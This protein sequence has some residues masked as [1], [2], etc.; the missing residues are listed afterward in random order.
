MR[1]VVNC[2]C[3]F[4]V[5]TFVTC[6]GVGI[7]FVTAIIHRVLVLLLD[8]YQLWSLE[9]HSSTVRL[10]IDLSL[11]APLAGSFFPAHVSMALHGA[12]VL[13]A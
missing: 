2:R 4:E 3:V 12:T 6:V 7:A 8:T 5:K 13:Y 9:A 11:R 1:V 10:R